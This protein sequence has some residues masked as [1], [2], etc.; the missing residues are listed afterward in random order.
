MEKIAK[1]TLTTTKNA[2]KPEFWIKKIQGKKKKLG[3]TSLTFSPPWKSNLHDILL[4]SVLT[5]EPFALK[6]I[7]E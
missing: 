3:L 5:P 6:V 7:P 1:A 4:N 2:R